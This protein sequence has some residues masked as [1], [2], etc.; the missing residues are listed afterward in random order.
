M[1]D[2]SI[3]EKINHFL[4]AYSCAE[5]EFVFLRGYKEYKGRDQPQRVYYEMM[6]CEK[7]D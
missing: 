1:E 6:G 4:S 3:S 7:N 5:I 2:S